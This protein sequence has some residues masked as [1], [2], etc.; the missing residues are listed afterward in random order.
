MTAHHGDDLMETIL[1]R[2]VRG[3]TLKGYAGFKSISTDRGYKIARPLIYLTKDEILE[4]L[5]EKSEDYNS[6]AI[7]ELKLGGAY[8]NYN[9]LQLIRNEENETYKSGSNFDKYSLFKNGNK[10]SMKT[11]QKQ[12]VN[13]SKLNSGKTLGWLFSVEMVGSQAKIQLTRTI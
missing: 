1:M 8:T 3:S 12:F 13:G 10:F 5:N 11:F 4:I 6:D 2:M 7:A 9:L